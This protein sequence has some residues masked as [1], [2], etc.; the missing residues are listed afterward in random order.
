MPR[1]CVDDIMMGRYGASVG[2][3]LGGKAGAY[4]VALVKM[5][6]ERELLDPSWVRLF[7]LSDHFQR[8]LKRISRSAQNGFNKVDLAEIGVPLAPLP[9]QHR[10]A[11]KVD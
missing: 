5:I 11:K 1:N 9:E 8:P 10:I 2:K 7:L 6:F 4:N 3:I